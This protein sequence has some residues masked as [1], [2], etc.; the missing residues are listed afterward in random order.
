MK[1]YIIARYKPEITAEQKERFAPEILKLFQETLSV[2]GIRAVE[3]KTNCVARENRYDVMII[4]TMDAAALP[5]YDGCPAHHTWKNTY[6]QY[7]EKKA[8]FDCEE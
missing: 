1:H 5:A 3:V 4:L 2:P 6:G 8:I 7:L